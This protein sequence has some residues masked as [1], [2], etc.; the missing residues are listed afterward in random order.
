MLDDFQELI[1]GGRST[2]LT[3]AATD[4]ERNAELLREELATLKATDILDAVSLATAKNETTFTLTGLPGPQ[5]AA[6]R[7]RA[8]ETLV[9]GMKAVVVPKR[10]KTGFPVWCVQVSWES[11][12]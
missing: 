11:R 6:R 10:G 8:I 4:A 5:A 2:P 1:K 12:L 3:P 9:P 7:A